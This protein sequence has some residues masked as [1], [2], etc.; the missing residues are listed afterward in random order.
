MTGPEIVDYSKE[1]LAALLNR[2]PEIV[3]ARTSPTQKLLIV[4]S[5]Q[6]LGHI[7]AVT[8]DGVNDS[9]ALK[10]AD[11]GVA[12]GITGTDVSRDAADMVLLDDNFSS[13]VA[14]VEQGRVVSDNLQKSIAYVLTSNAPEI[15]PFVLQ[16]VLAIPLPLSIA[17]VLVIDA[18]TD[19]WPS[20][21]LAYEQPEENVMRREPRDPYTHRLV[22]GR[23]LA[24]AYLQ[25]GGVQAAAALVSYYIVFIDHGFN[26]GALLNTGPDW[27]DPNVAITD[28]YG[29]VWSEDRRQVLHEM[30]QTATFLAIVCTQI[31]DLL[32]CRCRRDSLVSRGCTNWQLNS[33]IVSQVKAT[34][35]HT[36]VT[37][38]HTAA[39]A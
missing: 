34:P 18:V 16:V 27:D 33:A 17:L 31:A 36:L 39:H 3:F 35:T 37:R 11:V 9:P 14:A 32:M 24:A 5:F 4:E 10:K 13:I 15:V 25:V 38:T 21:S 12:M 19:L 28:S 20:I 1:R 6:S 30:A 23:L 7:V 2:F 22:S 26:P 29:R 8:G